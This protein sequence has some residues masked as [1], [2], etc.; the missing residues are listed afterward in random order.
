MEAALLIKTNEGEVSTSQLSTLISI[1]QSSKKINKGSSVREI[2]S[3][4]LVE[5][6]VIVTEDALFNLFFMAIDTEDRELIYKN[7]GF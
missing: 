1:L 6:D 4:L 3:A 5:F 2:Q 7:A